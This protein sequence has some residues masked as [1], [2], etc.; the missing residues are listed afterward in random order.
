MSCA[1]SLVLEKYTMPESGSDPETA[2][3]HVSLT[4]NQ[5]SRNNIGLNIYHVTSA[6]P[7]VLTRIEY[8]RVSTSN[9]SNE[10]IVLSNEDPA[11]NGADAAAPSATSNMPGRVLVLDFIY[12]S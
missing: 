7:I 12:T 9:V 3:L 10:F 8:E 2:A 1:Y 6:A 11:K 4:A 5:G